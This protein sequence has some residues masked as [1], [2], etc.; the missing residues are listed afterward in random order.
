MKICT[1]N[2]LIKQNFNGV[3]LNALQQFWHTTKSFQCI[4][5]PKRQNLLLY[6]EGCRITYTDKQ[7][8]TYIANSGDIVYT[9]MGSEYKA[10][11][12]DFQSP[13]AHT[14]G[15]NFFLL[16]QAGEPVV[17]SEGI[18]VFH[19]PQKNALG[20]LFHQ[21]LL[22][23]LHQPYVRS[24]ILLMEI[25]SALADQ[26]EN[27]TLPTHIIRALEYLSDHIEENPS[28]AK[29]AELCNIS[30]VYFRKQFKSYM[31]TTPLEYRN[32]LRLNR[33]RSYL[34]Y[35]DISV[36][37]TADMLGYATVSHFIKEF[38][39]Q[40]GCAPLQYRKLHRMDRGSP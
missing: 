29:L 18:Q 28:I 10:Q 22:F 12:S 14:V 33:A 13:D 23:D 20:L 27:K 9:P 25:L 34:E 4:G 40:Y 32:A 19:S 35:G 37:E 1:P 26:T 6:L 11:L 30:Q 15:I 16:S 36:Q 24:R 5:A 21:A 38:K 17:L 2:Q 31:G 7:G 8:N 3:F 39:K